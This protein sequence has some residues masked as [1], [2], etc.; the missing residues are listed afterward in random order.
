MSARAVCVAAHAPRL[1]EQIAFGLRH[2]GFD[3]E[4]CCTV[5]GVPRA[6]AAAGAGVVVLGDDLPGELG[7][8]ACARLRRSDAH[9]GLVLLGTGEGR[10]PRIAARSAGADAYL[11]LPLDAQELLLVVSRLHERTE[12][13]RLEARRAGGLPGRPQTSSAAWSLDLRAG[14]LVAPNGLRKRVSHSER[15]LLGALAGEPQPRSHVEL[16]A[17]LG[18]SADGMDKHRLEVIVSR[19]RSGVQRETG[20]ALPLAAVRGL[21]YE[22]GGVRVL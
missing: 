17:V 14:Q 18:L 15:L 2:E 12:A 20:L 6:L 8:A 1:R 11:P 10:E 7:P 4:T 21:G 5:Q 3:V 19:L 9:L 16:A 13:Q 22:L